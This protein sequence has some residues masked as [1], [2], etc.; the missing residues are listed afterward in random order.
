MWLWMALA[1]AGGEMPYDGVDQDEDGVDLVDVDGDGFA[2]TLAFG[3]D[4][5]DR[6]SRVRPDAADWRKDGVD[7]DCDGADG[8][9]PP[10]AGQMPIAGDVLVQGL[11]RAQRAFGRAIAACLRRVC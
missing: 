7:Q 4:C 11:N 10:P 1:L 2:S 9:D 8:E 6:D 3:L 5:N